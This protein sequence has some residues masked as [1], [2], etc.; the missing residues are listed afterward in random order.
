MRVVAEEMLMMRPL[1]QTGQR[2]LN[3]EERRFDVDLEG[4]LKGV[5]RDRLDRGAVE[6]AGVVDQDVEGRVADRCVELSKE[7]LDLSPDAV[8]SKLGA[9]REGVPAAR[10]DRLNHVPGLRLASAVVDGD[11]RAVAG[12]ALGNRPPD[13]PRSAGD[14]R[15]L[16]AQAAHPVFLSQSS[17]GHRPVNEVATRRRPVLPVAPRTRT[18]LLTALLAC[19][20]PAPTVALSCALMNG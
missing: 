17:A 12:Q 10:F 18:V 14:Q 7:R 8:D 2:L 6:D 13:A 15:R 1:S 5:W 9:D 16:S 19:G 4:A 11:A 3:D 20:W